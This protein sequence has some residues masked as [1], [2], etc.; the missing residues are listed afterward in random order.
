MVLSNPPLLWL[1][2]RSGIC[3]FTRMLQYVYEVT[4]FR[5]SRVKLEAGEYNLERSVFNVFAEVVMIRV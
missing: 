2:A 5:K 4:M 3:Q 1:H